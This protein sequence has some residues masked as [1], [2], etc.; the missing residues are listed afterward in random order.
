MVARTDSRAGSGDLAFIAITTGTPSSTTC[1][2]KHCVCGIV[3]S[4]YAE[5]PFVIGPD[6]RSLLMLA[7][8]GSRVD[9]WAHCNAQ[10]ND[11]RPA[12]YSVSTRI[13]FA[14][15][16]NAGLPP[17]GSVPVFITW[18]ATLCASHWQ[19]AFCPYLGVGSGATLVTYCLYPRYVRLA[20]VNCLNTCCTLS[21]FTVAISLGP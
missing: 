13:R 17:A 11:R 18:P 4:R 2:A 9:H 12:R 15:T 8:A 16:D 5:S 10:G 6:R 21:S 20:D 7:N 3:R 1:L 14:C 19:G